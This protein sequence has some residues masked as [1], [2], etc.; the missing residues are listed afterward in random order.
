MKLSDVVG[1]SGL[2]IYAEIGLIL[3]FIVFVLIVARV[4]WPSRKEEVERDR[5]L[6]LDD[7]DAAA[8]KRGES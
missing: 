7:E 3:F 4:F 5:F 1:H 2:A 6:A 8:E